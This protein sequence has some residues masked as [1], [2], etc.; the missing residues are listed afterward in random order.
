MDT[1]RH[2]PLE[3]SHMDRQPSHA[4]QIHSSTNN[5]RLLTTLR[6]GQTATIQSLCGGAGFRSRLAALGFT[7]GASIKMLQNLGQ[8]P[9]IVTIRDT[10]IALG[11]GEA[12]RIRVRPE[13]RKL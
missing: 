2:N 3:G 10:R 12:C 13:Q 7:P 6:S 9:I 1:R 8:G 4:Q 11:R 5:A